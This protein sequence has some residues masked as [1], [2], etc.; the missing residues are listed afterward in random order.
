M[1]YIHAESLEK[2]IKDDIEDLVKTE[3]VNLNLIPAENDI[4]KEELVVKRRELERIASMRHRAAEA[5][6][7]GQ[8]DLDFFT[9]RKLALSE[10][11][12]NIKKDIETLESKIN[13]HLSQEEAKE[14]SDLWMQTA[15][16]FLSEKDF[17]KS[18]AMLQRIIDRIEVKS[19]DDAKVFYRA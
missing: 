17:V 3:G 8:Y 16:S 12:Q 14:R 9:Q 4:F 13:G 15:S 5:Y 11:E 10:Q 2:L 7:A 18:K 6:E 19:K 1:G